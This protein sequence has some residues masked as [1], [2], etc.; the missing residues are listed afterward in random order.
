MS[1][2]HSHKKGSRIRTPDGVMSLP[3]DLHHELD[4]Q[5]TAHGYDTLWSEMVQAA[6]LGVKLQ[7]AMTDRADEI[8]H[9][10]GAIGNFRQQ[11]RA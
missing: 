8:I 4:E 10:T 1:Q 7:R 2:Q 9:N 6:R 11:G 5:K 3:D